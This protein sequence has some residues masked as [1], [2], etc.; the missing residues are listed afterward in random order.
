MSEQSAKL[1]QLVNDNIAATHKSVSEISDAIAETASASLNRAMQGTDQMRVTLSDVVRGSIEA[2]CDVGGDIGTAA[3]AT[4]L[5]VASSMRK[6]GG[7]SVDAI[8]AAARAVIE[9]TK[10]LHGDL[11]KAAKGA[12]E[13]AATAAR[14]AGADMTESVAAAATAAVEAAEKIDATAAQQVR[15]AVKVGAH[16]E[17]DAAAKPKSRR[18]AATS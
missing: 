5:G 13:G 11:G 14:K 10:D 4:M 3:E 6:A 1:M 8:R 17:K 9:I 2:V 7:D 15:D 12:I 16:C 18:T